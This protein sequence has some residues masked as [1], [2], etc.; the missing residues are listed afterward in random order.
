MLNKFNQSFG[1]PVLSVDSIKLIKSY[2]IKT[3]IYND[4]QNLYFI[5][6]LSLNVVNP[7]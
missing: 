1:L 6:Y 5:L 4:K 2:T 3:F 7:F